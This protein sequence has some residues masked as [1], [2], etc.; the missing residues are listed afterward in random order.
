MNIPLNFRNDA[1]YILGQ[2]PLKLSIVLVQL[3]RFYWL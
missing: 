1:K 3:F 2:F